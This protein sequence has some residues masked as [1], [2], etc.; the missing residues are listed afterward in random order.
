MPLILKG[1]H[2]LQRDC[3]SDVDI[4]RRDVDPEFHAQRPP[5]LQLRLEA[6]CRQQVDG[7]PGERLQTHGEPM[8]D[9]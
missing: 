6:S 8:V 7:V 5:E 3:P 4:G 9:E 2:P 1:P